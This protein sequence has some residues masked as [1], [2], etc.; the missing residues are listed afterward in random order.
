MRL[1]FIIGII[2]HF[3]YPD[4]EE[5]TGRQCI[6]LEYA[7]GCDLRSKF[8]KDTRV[9]EPVALNWITQGCLGLLKMH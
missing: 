7:D 2:E 3:P 9:P 5:D 6:V 1:P 8:D 4:D